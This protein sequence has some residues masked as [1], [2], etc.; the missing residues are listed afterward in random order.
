MLFSVLIPA[1]N[2]EATIGYAINS[3][4]SQIVKGEFEVLVYDDGSSDSTVAV[5]ERCGHDDSRV[6]LIRAAKNGG[7]SRA[8]NMLLQEA[9]GDWIAFLDSD[10]IFLP[11][12]LAICLETAIIHR[13]DFVTHDLGYLRADGQVVGHIR[14]VEFLQASLLRRELTSTLRFSEALSA[15][16]DSQFF[17]L[18]KRRASH[19][20]LPN[21]LTAIRIR[22]DSL[23]DRFWFQKR[24]I[25]LWHSVHKDLTPPYDMN[26]YMEFYRSLPRAERLNY[27]RRW[28]GQKFG[29][30]AAGA[31]F[32]GNR[33]IA[34]GYLIG[35]FLLNPS[36]FVSR[37]RG[38]RL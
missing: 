28:F 36:Y 34:A 1:F 33:F 13:S 17:F 32:A 20:H 12:K 22:K 30:S 6:R 25:E 3:A 10:D 18:L 37:V 16:E 8:R 4:L 11:D 35:S 19:V 7:A 38:Q 9:R 24:L 15:G 5:A 27:L 21:V 29:R 23:T 26:G 14:N 31:M 2:T